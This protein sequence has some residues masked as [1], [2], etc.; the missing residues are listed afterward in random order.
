MNGN[1]A[2]ETV[3]QFKKDISSFSDSDLKDTIE[4]IKKELIEKGII[5]NTGEKV[6]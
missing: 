1:L 4:D 2:S 3:E 5:D 6:C